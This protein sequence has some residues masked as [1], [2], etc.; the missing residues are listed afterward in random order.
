MLACWHLITKCFYN[1]FLCLLMNTA[2]VAA[3]L[4][5]QPKLVR[6]SVAIRQLRHAVVAAFSSHFADDFSAD[7]GERK[8]NSNYIFF[9]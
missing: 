4:Q 2:E 5:K 7:K 3:C 9:K 6:L 1:V 8:F